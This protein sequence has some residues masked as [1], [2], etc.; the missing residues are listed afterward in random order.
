MKLVEYR[1]KKKLEFIKTVK[2]EVINVG[3]SASTFA[4]YFHQRSDYD[5]KKPV[6]ELLRKGVTF[7]LLFLDPNS[8]IA[9]AYADDRGES[10]LLNKIHTS[11][12][13]FE[14]LRDEFERADYLGKIELLVY[15]HFPCY[16]MLMIDSEKH[17]GRVMVSNYLY[18]LKRAD[19]PVVEIKKSS[20]RI[21]FERH[22]QSLDK[23]ISECRKV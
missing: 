13:F 22:K 4:S 9:K 12:E 1:S 2:S 6:E 21:F 23:L 15:S 19:N 5:F 17:E 18:G 8:R 20:N 3:V 10:K 16:H 14:G 11:I 7:K